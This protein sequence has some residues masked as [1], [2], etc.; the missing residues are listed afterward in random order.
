MYTPEGFAASEQARDEGFDSLLCAHV[1]EHMPFDQAAE[2]IGRHLRFVRAGGRVVLIA[3][4]E[5]G[6]RSD[7]T[8]VEFMDFEKLER[9]LRSNGLA[10]ERRY[11]FP[12]PRLVGSV[13]P[14]N[15]F[16]VVGRRPD[17]A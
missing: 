12:F 15:E 1:V 4:Q 2:L 11:S 5:A 6:Y 8:H 13:F 3:P 9:L 16:V 7:D 17:S 10:E 14:H